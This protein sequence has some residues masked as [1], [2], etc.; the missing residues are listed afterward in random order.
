MIDIFVDYPGIWAVFSGPDGKYI[1]R[2]KNVNKYIDLNEEIKLQPVFSY[3]SGLVET[4]NGIAMQVLL[5]PFDLFVSFN[6]PVFFRRGCFT[7]YSRFDEMDPA[8]RREYEKVVAK[9]V[10]IAEQSRAQ[11]SGISLASTMPQDPNNGPLIF[12]K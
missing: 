4:E 10:V 9:G 12:S 7:S 11:K 2:Q 5:N 8:D 6:S 1:G 3:M